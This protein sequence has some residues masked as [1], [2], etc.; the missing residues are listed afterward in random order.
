MGLA[1]VGD[2]VQVVIDTLAA[3]Q[4]ATAGPVGTVVA[5]IVLSGQILTGSAKASSG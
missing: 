1:R 3:G 5:P 2:V 4:I